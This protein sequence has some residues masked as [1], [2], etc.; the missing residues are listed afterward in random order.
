MMVF[1]W[2]MASGAV[3]GS[4]QTG[5]L[6]TFK[7][8]LFASP[9]EVARAAAHASATAAA[10][11]GAQRSGNFGTREVLLVASGD[12]VV[13]VGGGIETMIT[14]NATG[15]TIRQI[16]LPPVHGAPAPGG[17]SGGIA[18]GPTSGSIGQLGRFSFTHK[19]IARR[20]LQAT[21]GANA[22]AAGPG[23]TGA[24]LKHCGVGVVTISIPKSGGDEIDAPRTTI[25]ASVVGA[26]AVRPGSGLF[27]WFASAGSGGQRSKARAPLPEWCVLSTSLSLSLSLSFSF[28]LSLALSLSLSLS[29]AASRS[30]S[31]LLPL[32]FLPFAALTR[33][34][35]PHRTAVIHFRCVRPPPSRIIAGT[36]PCWS[37]S[38]RV[39][40]A[41]R[42]RAIR[43]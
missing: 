41:S 22:H 5:P 18:F 6:H 15:C 31:A 14:D 30:S 29:P 11:A 23:S 42:R 28:S 32:S 20:G 13:G 40:C 8:P 26:E 43:R 1:E 37:A 9:E 34:R 21:T 10:S 24:S 4:T 27:S 3:G 36:P 16:V 12:G 2:K 38:T 7:P 17:A 35:R 25:D 39:R 33:H 19:S